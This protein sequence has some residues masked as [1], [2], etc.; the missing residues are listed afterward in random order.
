[1]TA[2]MPPPGTRPNQPGRRAPV[3]IPGA[4]MGFAEQMLPPWAHER[5]KDYFTY[6]VDFLPLPAAT[7][8]VADFAIQNDSDFFV[9]LATLNASSTAS[10]PVTDTDPQLLILLRD[11]GSGRNLENR[12]SHVLNVMGTAQRPFYLP[13]AKFIERG[14]TFSTQLQSLETVDL[15]VRVSYSGFKV[16]DFPAAR[17]RRY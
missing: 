2:V 13:N 15:N 6:S 12:S 10:P 17:V 8:Q 1:M 9:I 14:S 4:I 5:A 16:F 11:A 3:T 7:T